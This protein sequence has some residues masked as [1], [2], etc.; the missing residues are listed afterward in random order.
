MNAVE[1]NSSSIDATIAS[2]RTSGYRV[3]SG[4]AARGFA[5]DWLKK[6]EPAIV[7]K[8]DGE[9]LVLVVMRRTTDPLSPELRQLAELAEVVERHP[10]WVLELLWLGDEEV[11]ATP[12]D[13]EDLIARAQRVLDVDVEAA[14]L[15]LWPA[16]EASLQLQASRLGIEASRPSLLLAELYSL[17]RL[18]ER[19]FSELNAAQEMRNDV[20]HRV[21]GSEVDAAVVSR[22]AEIAR[23]LADPHYVTTD[24]MIEWFR[25]HYMDPANGVPYDSSEGGYLYVNGGPYDA[26]DVLS[27]RFPE[28][29]PDELQDAVSELEHESHEWVRTD[30]Y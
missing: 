12:K 8:R 2:L 24:Q 14:L 27:D 26:L 7:A 19:H 3:M 10:G 16:V 1:F 4:S 30:E 25:D 13:V 28:A 9:F 23:R 22:L 5:P 18:S 17:G 29:L 21:G 6:F 20:A 15:L 11:G